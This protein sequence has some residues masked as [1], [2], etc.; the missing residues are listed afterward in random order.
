M[1]DKAAQE[2]ALLAQINADP[3]LQSYAVRRGRRSQNFKNER[4]NDWAQE[5]RCE[6][7]CST[8]HKRWCKWR[9]KIKSHRLKR[10]LEEFRD[11][12]RESLEQQLFSSAPIYK[13]LELTSLADSIA[14]P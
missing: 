1:A 14:A 4:P 12:A 5:W 9:P 13:D 11:S 6:S 3:K 2:Q 10:W 7:V 8:W